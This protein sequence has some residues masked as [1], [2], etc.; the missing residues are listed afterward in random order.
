MP[1]VCKSCQL[2]VRKHNG[3]KNIVS[4][5]CVCFRLSFED[6]AEDA[7]LNPAQ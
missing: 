6:H 4:T 2:C 3:E 5:V 7:G 1:K